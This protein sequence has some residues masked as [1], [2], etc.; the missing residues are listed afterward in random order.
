MLGRAQ[1]LPIVPPGLCP[2]VRIFNHPNGPQSPS[3]PLHLTTGIDNKG[4]FP[5][6]QNRAPEDDQKVTLAN[7]RGALYFL[8]GRIVILD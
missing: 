3:W 4:L 2:A 1:I 5:A 7:R 8:R 6:G